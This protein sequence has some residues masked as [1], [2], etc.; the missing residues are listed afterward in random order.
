MIIKWNLGIVFP[1]K[2]VLLE[3]WLAD[4]SVA[5]H[6]CRPAPFALKEALINGWLPAGKSGFIQV[7][8]NTQ[9]QLGGKIGWFPCYLS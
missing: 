6:D 5:D 7:V 8:F 1:D 9:G 3:T 2:P 4:Y